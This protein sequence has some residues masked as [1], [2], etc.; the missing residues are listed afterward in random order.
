MGFTR[1]LFQKR[2]YNCTK[3]ISK[4]GYMLYVKDVKGRV[5]CTLPIYFY[6]TRYNLQFSY[7]VWKSTET[8]NN[9]TYIVKCPYPETLLLHKYRYWSLVR[10]SIEEKRKVYTDNKNIVDIDIHIK[11]T[12]K[13]ALLFNS[14]GEVIPVQSLEL[15]L[16]L[17]K[18]M[19]VFTK[20]TVQNSAIYLDAD[21]FRK[22]YWELLLGELEKKMVDYQDM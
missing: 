2:R 4:G 17:C 6:T 22:Q 8:Y 7:P 21:D 15:G 20:N 18:Y 13:Y 5:D 9:K 3:S 19:T 16:V 10:G 1:I 12:K 14:L 11:A